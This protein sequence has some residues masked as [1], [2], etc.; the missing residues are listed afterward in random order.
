MTA[1]A[2]VVEA[3]R[4]LVDALRA[5]GFPV[6]GGARA[7]LTDSGSDE[8][9]ALNE[10]AVAFS[11]ALNTPHPA[12]QDAREA[13]ASMADSLKRI[14]DMLDGTAAGICVSQTI[15]GGRRDGQ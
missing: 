6:S 14:A 1:S 4:A 8:A 10:A 11:D 7:S 13:V 3:G 15:F 5:Y 12:E 9:Y 2:S